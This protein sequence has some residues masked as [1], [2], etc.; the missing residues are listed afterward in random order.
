VTLSSQFLALFSARE[1]NGHSVLIVINSIITTPPCWFSIEIALDQSVLLFRS[2]LI[3]KQLGGSAAVSVLFV[4]CP[5][6]PV[7]SELLLSSHSN[8]FA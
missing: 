4:D 2:S 3:P 1:E 8:S 6:P 5:C 7:Q